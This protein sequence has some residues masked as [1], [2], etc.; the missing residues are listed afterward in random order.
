MRIGITLLILSF[1][2]QLC[3]KKAQTLQ[4]AI[5]HCMGACWPELS[6]SSSNPIRRG[7]RNSAQRRITWRNTGKICGR[8]SAPVQHSDSAGRLLQD[9]INLRGSRWPASVSHRKRIL[10]LR[11]LLVLNMLTYLQLCGSYGHSHALV[12]AWGIFATDAEKHTSILVGYWRD[13]QLLA[14]GALLHKNYEALGC[15]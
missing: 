13:V 1:H 3:C 10:R 4:G 6:R 15:L 14:T 2:H 5:S 9:G 11:L 8:I 7:I 12:A